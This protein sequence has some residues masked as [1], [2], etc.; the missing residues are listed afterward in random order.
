M[1]KNKTAKVILIEDDMNFA[2][3]SAVSLFKSGGVFIYPTDTIYGIGGNPFIKETIDKIIKIK[4]RQ[5]DQKFIFLI[6][7]LDILKN[8]VQINNKKLP[9]FLKKIWPAPVTVILE[10]KKNIS[11]LFNSPDAAFR[12]PDH[13]FCSSLLAVLDMPLIST[14]V[15][16][17]GNKPINNKKIIRQE[18]GAK[19]DAIF[20]SKKKLKNPASTIIDLTGNNPVL[21]REGIVKFETILELF[22][23]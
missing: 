16:K 5:K 13:K 23:S 4:G 15:N 6:R 9:G 8:F 21:V 3:S 7:N 11:R 10:L 2:I 22:Y 14:S 20:F 19:V 18:F 17:S 1:I 12:I